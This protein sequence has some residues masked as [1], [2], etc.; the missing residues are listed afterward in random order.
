MT[1]RDDITHNLRTCFHSLGS[2]LDGLTP[3]QWDTRSLCPA[4][5]VQGVA[6]HVALIETGL[7]G[8]RP[9]GDSNPFG[10]MG[11]IA[12]GLAAMSHREL[13]AHYHDV[14]ADRLVELEAMTD[15]EFDAPS[16]TPVGK[17]S[18]ARFMAIRVFDVWVHEQDIRVPLGLPG[19][20]SGPAAEMA[21]DEVEGSI[22]Y[23]VGKKIGLTDGQGIVFHVRGDVERDIAVK[24]IGRATRV[25]DL[26]DPDVAVTVDFLT[27]ML[28][29]CG[30]VDPEAEIAAGRISWTGDDE[31]G[32]RAAR[33]LAFTM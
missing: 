15:E 16:F 1:Q 28:L 22:G 18:Y 33:N 32:A 5:T 13:L 7:L 8:W 29:A 23:I 10:R 14:V 25:P 2:L 30:R 24:V 12:P 21:L 3:E 26:A 6:E 20:T 31:L 9:E 27:F 11:Q 4:W 17:G 19:H